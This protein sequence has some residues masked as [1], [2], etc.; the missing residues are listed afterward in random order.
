MKWTGTNPADSKILAFMIR[1]E[2]PPYRTNPAVR[3]FR[4]EKASWLGLIV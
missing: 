3:A 4:T 1:T 2:Y